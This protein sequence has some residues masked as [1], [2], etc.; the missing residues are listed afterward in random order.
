MN[1]VERIEELIYVELSVVRELRDNFQEE[2][3]AGYQ[4]NQIQIQEIRKERQEILLALRLTKQ[5]IAEELRRQGVDRFEDLKYGA[6]RQLA[7][8]IEKIQ[9]VVLSISQLRECIL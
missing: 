2:L 3:K 9:E 4:G 6:F 8:I 7:S 1:N 5:K